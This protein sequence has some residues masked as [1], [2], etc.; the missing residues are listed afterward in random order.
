[1]NDDTTRIGGAFLVGG[2][3]GAAI[4]L[5]YAPQSGRSTRKDIARAVRRGKNITVDLIEDTVDEVNNFVGDLQERAADI[6]D[7]GVELSDKARK[8]LMTT[9]EHGQKTIEKQRNKLC[10]V[11]GLCGVEKQTDGADYC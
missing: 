1:M 7:Q 11:L 6:V 9:L 3:I 5:L 2:L 8:E 10:E 4:A